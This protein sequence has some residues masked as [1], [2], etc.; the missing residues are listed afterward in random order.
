MSG[1]RSFS[2]ESVCADLKWIVLI[3]AR[4]D[5]LSITFLRQTDSVDALAS[6][7]NGFIASLMWRRITSSAR[8]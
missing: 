6:M 3:S 5:L 1:G 4:A 7:E 8:H 2:S